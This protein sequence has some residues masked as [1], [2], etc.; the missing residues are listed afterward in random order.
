MGEWMNFF[1]SVKGGKV[2]DFYDEWAIGITFY[3]HYSCEGMIRWLVNKTMKFSRLYK[4][5]WV[6]VVVS[7]K[8]LNL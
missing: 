6:N 1:L 3:S 4:F 8:Y 5:S 7:Q 2:T